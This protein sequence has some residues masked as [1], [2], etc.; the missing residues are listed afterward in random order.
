MSETIYDAKTAIRAREDFPALERNHNGRPLA[1]FDGPGGTQVP[2]AVIDAVSD[3]YRRYNANIHGMFVTTNET[4]AMLQSA[5]EAMAD[6]L[7]AESWRCISFGAN[8]TTL[9]FSLA[10]ALA[11]DMKEGDEVV[12]TQLDHEANRGPWLNLR[13][14]GVVVKE[15]ALLPSGELDYDDMQKKITD[16]TRV[17]AVGMSSNALGTANDIAAARNFSRRVG[18]HL[19][20]DAVHYAPHHPIDV[21]A[22]DPDFLICSAYKFYG[23]HV[24]IL[25][26]RPG[27]LDALETDALSTQE[28]EAPY[29]IETG[30]LNHASIAGAL[31]A[32]DYIASYGN[33]ATRR[34][35]I[36][37]AMHAIATYEHDLAVRYY[38]EVRKIPGVTVVGPGFDGP[39]VPTV[40]VAI[41]GIEPIEAAK[42]LGEQAICVWDGDFYA[43]RA[44]EILGLKERGGVLRTG[45]S[46]YNTE[47]EV[48]RLLEG[49]KP[50]KK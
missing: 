31:A 6:F 30:T 19:V 50:L 21:Q 32:V 46:M 23:P 26:S 25:Y 1:Y 18:A 37:S 35:K 40:S 10:H 3:Y 29:K 43:A 27:A 24:G 41:D 45:I 11:K 8:M 34:E 38:D 16:R 33:G 20:L 12:I 15:V 7:G 28:P 36:V 49:I 9:N 44:I 14:Y 17:V 5:R 22:I 39:R 47:E 48:E 42:Q 2:N 4:D 13:Q